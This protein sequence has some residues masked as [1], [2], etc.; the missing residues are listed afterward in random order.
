MSKNKKNVYFTKNTENAIVQ[1][2]KECNSLIKQQIYRD[3]IEYPINKLVENIINRFKFPYFDQATENLKNDVISFVIMNIHR[4]D[5]K[6]G[7]AFSYFSILVK[8]YLIMGNNENYKFKKIQ[9]VIDSSDFDQSFY[10]VDEDKHYKQ[11]ND[12]PEFI[13]LLI[14]YWENNINF[15]FSKKHDIMIADAIINLFKISGNIE[16]HNKKS[17]YLMI[18]E[19]TGLRTQY[20]TSVVNKMKVHNEKLMNI[21]YTNGYFDVNSPITKTF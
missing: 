3:E 15:I 8:N 14:Q 12:M 9:Q 20:I 17:L 16:N 11:Q 18:R 4:Y 1:Y 7:K 13:E 10:L 2:N 19:M 6:K 21:Y 5:Q